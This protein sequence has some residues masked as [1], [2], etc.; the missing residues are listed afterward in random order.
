MLVH[1][2]IVGLDLQHLKQLVDVA[3]ESIVRMMLLPKSFLGGKD[4]LMFRD[5]PFRNA[6]SSGSDID[7]D[8]RSF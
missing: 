3:I 4:T 1:F 2:D 8:V 7:S 5:V 6:L